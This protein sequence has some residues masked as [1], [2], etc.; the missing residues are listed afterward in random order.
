[1]PLNGREGTLSSLSPLREVPVLEVQGVCCGAVEMQI[2]AGHPA[3]LGLRPHT[4]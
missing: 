1:M 3:R 2:Q 4:P